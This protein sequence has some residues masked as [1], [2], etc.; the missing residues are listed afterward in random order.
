VRYDFDEEVALKYYRLQKIS[1]GVIAL[2]AGVGGELPGPTAVGTGRGRDQ[3]VELST[4]IEQ[5]NERFGTEFKPADQLFLDSVREDAVADEQLRQ[6]ALANSI[7]NFKY[8][9][10][11]ALEGLFIDRMEQNEEIFNRFMSDSSFQ[12]VVEETLRHQ[13]YAR[14]HEEESAPAPATAER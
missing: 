13:V 2:Q 5:L 3:E 12:Q 9:F 11:K 1:E 8:V 10:S 4:L 14:I 6:A 7:E